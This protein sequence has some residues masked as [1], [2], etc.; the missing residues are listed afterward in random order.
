MGGKNEGNKGEKFKC[1]I[2]S[3]EDCKILKIQTFQKMSCKCSENNCSISDSVK[4]TLFW[5]Y[6]W[7]WVATFT[8][9]K[10]EFEG[11]LVPG[12]TDGNYTDNLCS[13]RKVKHY[14]W[15]NFASCKKEVIIQASHSHTQGNCV[16]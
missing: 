15:P 5:I 13:F 14:L 8:L 3:M 16:N 7:S 2:L 9:S 6:L 10:K 4:W 11:G 1:E 12:V